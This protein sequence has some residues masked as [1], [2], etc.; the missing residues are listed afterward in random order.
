VVGNDASGTWIKLTAI[1]TIED[2][3]RAVFRGFRQ[4]IELEHDPEQRVSV[5]GTASAP[6]R[7]IDV[8]LVALSMFCLGGSCAISQGQA[9]GCTQT[10]FAKVVALDQ[11]FYVNRYGALSRSSAMSSAWDGTSNRQGSGS[12]SGRGR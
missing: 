9:Q 11:A 1:A 6:G 5:F 2:I 4:I 12:S 7:R 3:A 8:A 10:V